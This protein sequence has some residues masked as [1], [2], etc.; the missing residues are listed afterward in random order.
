[1]CFSFQSQDSSRRD[2]N[3]AVQLQQSPK[4]TAEQLMHDRPWESAPAVPKHLP[5]LG[6]T[7]IDSKRGGYPGSL[8]WQALATLLISLMMIFALTYAE[9]ACDTQVRMR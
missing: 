7:G 3:Q 1:M 9:A 2:S 8:K 4:K 6:P 5:Y